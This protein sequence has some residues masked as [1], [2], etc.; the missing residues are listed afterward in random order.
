LTKGSVKFRSLVNAT[1]ATNIETRLC[2]APDGELLTCFL[3][4][5]PILNNTYDFNRSGLISRQFN[6]C[7]H[8]RT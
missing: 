4:L 1:S 6:H 2:E 5:A 7:H 8:R 3:N